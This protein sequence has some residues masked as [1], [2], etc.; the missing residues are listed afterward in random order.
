MT[1]DELQDLVDSLT[2]DN[3][4]LVAENLR[5]KDQLEQSGA[6]AAAVTTPPLQEYPRWLRR[7]DSEGNV[8][9]ET[10]VDTKEQADALGAGWE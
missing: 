4:A 2:K 1:K 8:V 10:L 6:P 3:D 5:L 7:K 9:E